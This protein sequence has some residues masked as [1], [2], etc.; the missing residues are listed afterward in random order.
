MTPER[1]FESNWPLAAEKKTIFLGAARKIFSPSYFVR[2]LGIWFD[3]VLKVKYSTIRIFKV[4]FLCQK[5]AES[6]WVFFI[7]EYKNG[8]LTLFFLFTTKLSYTQL[9]KWGH[10]TYRYAGSAPKQVNYSPWTE[11]ALRENLII[12]WPNGMNDTKSGSGSGSWNVSSTFGSKG[13]ICDL[14]R[15]NW[16]PPNECFESCPLCDESYS[17]DWTTCYDDIGFLEVVIETVKGGFQIEFVS[18]IRVN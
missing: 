6:L 4:F 7:E 10:P 15:G 16:P 17:C 11:V 9:F 3:L 18:I 5:S 1:H 14:N 8:S 13:P 12:V 2:A